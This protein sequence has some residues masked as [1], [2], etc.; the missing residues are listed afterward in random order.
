[1]K[2]DYGPVV[3]WMRERESIRQKREAGQPP[4]WT[5]DPILRDNRFCNVRREDDR[6]TR[7]VRTHIRER[8]AN[9]PHLWL[10]L[11]IARQINWP[12][13]LS[14]LMDYQRTWPSDAFN[15]KWMAERLQ[16]RAGKGE[17]VFTGAYII[18]AAGISARPGWNK[19][20]WVALKVI[21]NLWHDR[22]RFEVL[23]NGAPLM[24]TVH[25][26]LRE[27]NGWGDFLSYQAVVD[28][29]FTHLLDQA[30]DR[31]AWVAAGPGTLRGLNRIYGRDLYQ[32][33]PR[34][35][36]LAE[37]LALRDYLAKEVPEIPIDLSD[38]PSVLCE[39]DKY[40]RMSLGQGK[41]R[42]K[43]KPNSLP[44]G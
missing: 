28:M 11:C 24:Q 26:A 9:D 3:Y 35:Q 32:H 31:N 17:K 5:D 16:R 14:D 38:V 34:E 42:S 15:P 39:T 1:M 2:P 30:A 25:A 21:G 20:K 41:M 37:V 33:V 44:L 23:F 12:P 27:Y 29:R 7:W 36:T 43:F 40:L 4:P 8:Y 6:V 22:R 18:S 10:M 19:A 13:T